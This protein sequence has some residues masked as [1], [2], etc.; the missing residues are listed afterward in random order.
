MIIFAFILYVLFIVLLGASALLYLSP[1]LIGLV[2]IVI[3]NEISKI[4]RGKKAPV[5][6]HIITVA[7]MVFST[8]M[9]WKDIWEESVDTGLLPFIILVLYGIVSIAVLVA[10]EFTQKPKLYREVI[11]LEDLPEKTQKRICTCRVVAIICTVMAGMGMI[12]V[13]TESADI[14]ESLPP[15][16]LFGIAAIIC[17]AIVGKKHYKDTAGTI[18]DEIPD[19]FIGQVSDECREFLD[20]ELTEGF[21]QAGYDDCRQWDEDLKKGLK[22]STENPS[23][24]E[25]DWKLKETWEDYP[26]PDYNAIHTYCKVAFDDS[27]RTYYY[28]TRNPELK[29]G[30]AVYVS[31]GCNA[32][33]KIGVIVSMEDFEG[34][35]APFPL[36]KTKFIIGKV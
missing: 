17:W 5:V 26:A 29:V 32:P 20:E 33:K 31:F 15:T 9:L 12:V 4:K 21:A 24:K 11:A 23:G 2:T 34:Y 35:N 16:I 19:E 30:D 1:L 7:I 18:H 14:S 25:Y 8:G 36:E 28:R 27:G 6:W 22:K 10:P 3:A 13:A